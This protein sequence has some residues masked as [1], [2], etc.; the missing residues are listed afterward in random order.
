MDLAVYAGIK[1]I[2]SYAPAV[3]RNIA[4]EIIGKRRHSPPHIDI[5]D[6]EPEHFQQDLFL[7]PYESY[8][9]EQFLQQIQE[10]MTDLDDLERAAVQSLLDGESGPAMANRLGV[11]VDVSRGARERARKKLPMLDEWIRSRSRRDRDDQ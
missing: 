7:D 4:L 2:Q 9:L 1:D 10:G 11:T 5:A 6:S 3:V 8:R